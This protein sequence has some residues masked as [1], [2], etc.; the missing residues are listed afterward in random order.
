M[1]KK[2]KDYWWILFLFSPVIMVLLFVLLLFVLSSPR[3]VETVG[4]V[5]SVDEKYEILVKTVD[6][7]GM[8]GECVKPLGWETCGGVHMKAFLVKRGLIWDNTRQIEMPNNFPC[9]SESYD[10]CRAGLQSFEVN[11]DVFN[12]YGQEYR[13]N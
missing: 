4:K 12:W 8:Y 13:I 10:K 2:I 1:K 11:G 7:G 9:G 5:R 6:Y 3:R